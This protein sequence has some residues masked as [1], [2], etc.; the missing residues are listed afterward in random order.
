LSERAFRPRTIPSG[1]PRATLRDLAVPK[2]AGLCSGLGLAH[3]FPAA[4]QALELLTGK[5]LERP[6]RVRPDWQTDLTDDGSPFEFSVALGGA[7]PELRL[8]AEPQHSEPGPLSTWSAGLALNQRISQVPGVDLSR[9][10]AIRSLFAPLASIPHR[11]LIWHSAV[12][13]GSGDP[14]FKVYLNPRIVGVAGARSLTSRALRELQLP[15]VERYLAAEV[16]IE[17]DP[18]YFALDLRGGT[19]ARVKVYY[20]EARTAAVLDRDLAERGLARSG[21]VLRAVETLTAG[22]AAWDERTLL[23]C[24][25][26]DQ[27]TALP[28]V[29]VH[30]P[31]RSYVDNDEEALSRA[32]ELLDAASRRAL[33]GGVKRMANRP[34]EAARSLI[35]YVSVRLLPPDPTGGAS[36]VARVTTY[37]S[38]EMFSI[39]SPRS[40][41]GARELARGSYVREVSGAE[42]DDALSEVSSYVEEKREAF[43]NH[44]L[45]PALSG[46]VSTRQ[47]ERVIPHAALFAIG[48]D[49]V[50]R[51]V[52]E[53]IADEALRVACGLDE[54]AGE[55]G[56]VWHFAHSL[57]A[58]ETSGLESVFGASTEPVRRSVYGLAAQALAA[59][60]DSTRVALALALE[61]ASAE[62]LGHIASA[63]SD[64]QPSGLRWRPLGHVANARAGFELFSQRNR[65]QLA[66]VATNGTERRNQL[67][68]IERVFGSV[69]QLAD[70]LLQIAARE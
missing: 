26:F 34:L 23:T 25:A 64:R 43:A 56:L 33:D 31:I 14:S 59:D 10:D 45:F 55:G 5:W 65:R 21:S 12:V 42:A 44:A 61:S 35:T 37:L 68:A 70:H 62:L 24:Y 40:V 32:G 13:D 29:T 58:A 9:F 50:M 49:D 17:S 69:R 16:P 60:G 28:T 20:P 4:T 11:F 39:A 2:L 22:R 19:G 36:D 57:E 1:A 8:L 54:L 6:A 41:S 18:L 52:H 15:A 47:L 63:L 53:A 48:A 67:E 46:G 7:Q 51:Q 66:R 3:L 38:P 30:V 27:D